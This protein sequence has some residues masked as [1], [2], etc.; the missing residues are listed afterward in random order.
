MNSRPTGK[1]TDIPPSNA[2]IRLHVVDFGAD[3]GS[4]A[5]F[6]NEHLVLDMF[7]ETLKLSLHGVDNGEGE[8]S[9]GAESTQKLVSFFDGRGKLVSTELEPIIT[10]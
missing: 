2:W 10:F 4:P 1:E 9:G 5:S 6:R 7:V 8:I 3:V